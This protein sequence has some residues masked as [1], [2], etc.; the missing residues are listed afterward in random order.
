MLSQL[1]LLFCP[2]LCQP[3]G[4]KISERPP[5]QCWQ[6]GPWAGSVHSPHE[7]SSVHY[8]EHLC[9]IKVSFY[10]GSKQPGE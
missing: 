9:N 8:F 1:V 5:A 6:E 3:G 7:I 10:R 4:P 2:V